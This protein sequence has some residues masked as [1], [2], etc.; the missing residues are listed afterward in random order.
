MRALDRVRRQWTTL[1]EQDPLW[2]ILSRPDKKNGGWDQTAFFETG[3]AEIQKVLSTAQSLAPIRFGVAVDFGCGI[4]RLSQALALHFD[5]VIGVD[6]AESMIRTAIQLNHLPDRCE[7]VHNVAPNLSV[8]PDES[9]DFVYSTITLQHL[10]PALA[11]CYIREFFRVARLDAS[12]VFQ[13]PCRPRSIL[14]HTVKKALPVA[15]TNFIWRLRTNSPEAMETYSMPEK[16]VIQLVERS[17]GS[18]LSV[19]SDQNGPDGWQSRK[20]F[21]IRRA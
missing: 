16:K 4:G 5:R 18:V 15:V 11:R 1:G 8:W 7:Y 14:R 21:C 12:V 19:E 3:V 10:I 20:Y 13:L 2:A 9:A 6:V 17:G